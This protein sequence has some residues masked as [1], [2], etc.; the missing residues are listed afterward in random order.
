MTISEKYIECLKEAYS[1]FGS[2]EWAHFE[3]I[4]N[5]V[6]EAALAQLRARYPEIPQSLVDLLK[7]A[8]GTYYREYAGEKLCL[9]F[10]GSDVGGYPYYLLSAEQIVQSNDAV[11]Y[12]ADYVNRKYAEVDVD[13]KIIDDAAKMNWL[14]FSDCMNNGGSSQLWIDFSPS[15][16]GSRGQIVRFLHDP[17]EF[18]VIADSFDDYLQRLINRKCAFINED[19]MA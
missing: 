10:L 5:G 8:D 6:S 18:K 16:K 7:Y 1:E 4:K 13:E 2:K 3:Q 12:Y 15:A 17:D 14:H 11:N 19:S 9:L